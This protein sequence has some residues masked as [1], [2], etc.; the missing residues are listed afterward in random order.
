MRTVLDRPMVWFSKRASKQLKS[1]KPVFEKLKEVH[2]RYIKAEPRT[3]TSFWHTERPQVGLLAGAAWRAG[4]TAL[5]EYGC[6]RANHRGRRD[7]YIRTGEKTNFECE[8]K[9]LFADL[10][11]SS[12]VKQDFQRLL[13]NAVRQAASYGDAKHRLAL[14][15]VAPRIKKDVTQSEVNARCDELIRELNPGDRGSDCDALVWIH[16][17][18]R[19]DKKYFYPGIVLVVREAR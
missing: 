2:E 18:A 7:L 10:P 12:S 11:I 15:F 3:E 13:N 14:C 19:H 8:A 9:Y 4:A 1:L 6:D 5:E 16:G 17:K